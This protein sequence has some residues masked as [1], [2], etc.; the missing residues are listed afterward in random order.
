MGCVPSCDVAGK[1][2]AASPSGPSRPPKSGSSAGKPGKPT[3]PVKTGRNGK[4]KKVR[5][6]AGKIRRVLFYLL[7]TGLGLVLIAAGGFVY[8]YQT[9]DLPKAN[10]AFQTNTSYV[11]Y[12]DGKTELGEYA[13]QNRDTIPYD[14]MPQDIKDAVV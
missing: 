6:T 10:D 13:E 3:K 9:T 14:T 5:T 8:L 2:K 11:Y 1:R 12:S 7:L 4:P